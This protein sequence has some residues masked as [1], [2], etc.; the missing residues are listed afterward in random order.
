MKVADGVFIGMVKGG[1]LDPVGGYGWL[2]QADRVEYGTD[3][4]QFSAT[5]YGNHT[6]RSGEA[7][8]AD[9]ATCVD[10]YA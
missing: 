8:T 9:G 10:L 6:A 2:E 5:R 4:K 7:S 3:L 1:K